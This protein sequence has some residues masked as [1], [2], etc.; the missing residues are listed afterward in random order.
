M[1]TSGYIS[2][3]ID[4]NTQ[5]ILDAA[6]ALIKSK[7]P[8][9]LENDGN[10]DTWIIQA[11]AAQASDLKGIAL[12]VPDTIFMYFG[13]QLMGIPPL[14]ATSS[15]VPSTWTMSDTLGHTI[16]AGTQVAITDAVGQQ[17]A[18]Q[19]TADFTVPAGQSATAVGGVTLTSIEA[20][21]DMTGLGGNGYVATLIDNLAYVQTVALTALTS[22]GQD[23]ELSSEY[24]DRLARKLQRISNR[25]VLASDFSLAALDIDGVYRSLTLDGYNPANSTYNNERMIA[26]AAVDSLGQPVSAAIKT[27][28]QAYLDSQREVNFVVNTFD[29]TVT[30]V[31]VTFNVKVVVGYTATSA[32]ANALQALRDFLNPANWGH[33]PAV[34]D[35]TAQAQTWIV[36]PIVYYNKVIQVLSEATGVDRVIT[37]TMALH[38]NALGIADLTLPGAA[39]LADDGTINGT[40]TP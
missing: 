1:S 24:L 10:L 14:D 17:H 2:Y 12:D 5:D 7:V 34:T 4:S 25:P 13:S 27:Q 11:M 22:G 26:I 33:D 9:W 6:Y 37:M 21:A 39:P 19:T 3:P 30:Q 31:D 32:Q 36:S 23:A 29:P 8:D 28:L 20:G 18:F 15:T 16:P 38:G 35:A 40:A